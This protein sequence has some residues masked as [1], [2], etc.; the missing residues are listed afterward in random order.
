MSDANN[1]PIFTGPGSPRDVPPQPGD[2][3]ID[4]YNSAV[5]APIREE[6]LKPDPVAL[7]TSAKEL[8]DG[9]NQSPQCGATNIRQDCHV[10]QYRR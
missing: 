6:L 1:P 9:T 4:P 10:P 8:K 5:P 3:G 7:E 2:H